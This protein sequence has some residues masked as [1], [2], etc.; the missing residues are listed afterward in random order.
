MTQY[1]TVGEI[2]TKV[3]GATKVF[4]KYKIDFCCGGNQPLSKVGGANTAKILEEIEQCKINTQNNVNWEQQPIETIIEHLVGYY[5]DRHRKDLPELITLAQ[6]VETAHV[7]KKQCPHGLAELLREMLNEM[8][9][10]MLKVENVLFCNMT[11]GVKNDQDFN[12]VAELKNEHE[13]LGG[14]LIKIDMLTNNF[15]LPKEACNTWQAL[16]LGLAK[17]VDEL[18]EHVHMENNILFPKAI[19]RANDERV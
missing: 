17:F 9:V 15:T 14:D 18:T 7:D 8:E 2:A 1:L 3:P 16:Y 10:H 11:Q 6:K 5:H 13:E 19:K 4:R 12:C